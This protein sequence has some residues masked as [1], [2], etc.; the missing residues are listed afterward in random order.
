MTYT[1]YRAPLSTGRIV[2]ITLS[3]S[4]AF[5]VLA[6]LGIFAMAGAFEPKYQDCKAWA[7]IDG[8]SSLEASEWCDLHYTY[9][10]DTKD[11]TRD[12][13][14]SNSEGVE[15]DVQEFHNNVRDFIWGT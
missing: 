5:A 3:C 12:E 6:W 11:I 15:R 1:R 9:G 2:A 7:Q 14:R 13:Y 10:Y 4:L 8:A